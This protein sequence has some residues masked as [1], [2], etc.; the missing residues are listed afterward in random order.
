M[1]WIFENSRFITAS[2]DNVKCGYHV[3]WI[4]G[5]DNISKEH[6]MITGIRNG[7]SHLICI[8][9]PSMLHGADTVTGRGILFTC[10]ISDQNL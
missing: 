8:K 3:R 9:L 1:F 4:D 7:Q 10:T 6:A 5:E 2:R